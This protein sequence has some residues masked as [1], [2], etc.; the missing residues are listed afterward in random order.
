MVRIKQA[1]AKFDVTGPEVFDL[2]P[3][4]ASGDAEA[5]SMITTRTDFNQPTADEGVEWAALFGA[6]V[7]RAIVAFYDDHLLGIVVP[8]LS[9]AQVG[10]DFLQVFV[11]GGCNDGI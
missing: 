4:A 11:A 1:D 7:E 10:P 9:S 8:L 5:S 2:F 6:D 3:V